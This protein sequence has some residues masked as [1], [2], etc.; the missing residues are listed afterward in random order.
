LFNSAPAQFIS[1]MQKSQRTLLSVQDADM[2]LSDGHTM[3]LRQGL[4]ERTRLA[5]EA[6]SDSNQQQS[7]GISWRN[8]RSVIFHGNPLRRRPPEGDIGW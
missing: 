7:S 5:S 3:R 4:Q 2:Q 1:T 6:S 8:W